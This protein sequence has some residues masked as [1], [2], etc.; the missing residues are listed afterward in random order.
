MS[1]DEDLGIESVDDTS[2]MSSIY[3]YNGEDEQ[4]EVPKDVKHVR[5]SEQVSCLPPEIFEGCAQMETVEFA[6]N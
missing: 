3:I 5:I 6:K 1:S 4:G 2:S